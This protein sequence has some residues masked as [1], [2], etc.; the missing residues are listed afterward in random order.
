MSHNPTLLIVDDE[1][2][3]RRGLIN[4]VP[5]SALGID[6]IYEAENGR[7]ALL[8]LEEFQPDILLTDIRMPLMNGIDLATEVAARLPECKI[9]FLSG[10]SDKE[11]LKAAIHLGA[12]NYVEKPIDIEEVSNAVA[13]AVE[14]YWAEVRKPIGMV[15][16]MTV[17][18]SIVEKLVRNNAVINECIPLMESLNVRISEEGN[19]CTLVVKIIDTIESIQVPT[20]YHILEQ[21]LSDVFGK[22]QIIGSIKDMNHL[23][24]IIGIDKN[25]SLSDMRQFQYNMVYNHPSITAKIFASVS[26]V[27]VGLRNVFKAYQ[28]SVIGLQMLFFQGYG[29]IVIGNVPIVATD[30]EFSERNITKRFMNFLT[31]KAYDQLI[32]FIENEFKGIRFNNSLVVNDLKNA[33]FRMCILLHNHAR[34]EVAY[35]GDENSDNPYLWEQI[36]KIETLQELKLYL[37]NEIDMIVREVKLRENYS[38]SIRSVIQ[39][40]K[41]NYMDSEL[42]TKNLAD[43]VF[44][45]T[46][47]LS[48]LFKKETGGNISDFIRSVRIEAAKLKLRESNDSLKEI[49]EKVGYTDPNYF[50]KMFKKEVGRSPSDYRERQQT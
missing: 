4:N 35:E 43:Q 30:T 49:S 23:I 46:S 31:S 40:I 1:S 9:I 7:Q 38:T 6:T 22:Q 45:T 48:G 27:V 19:L 3:T 44:L 32:P 41:D 14:L 5:W 12:V 25:H 42:S 15:D 16:E 10:F 50:A 39:L 47:Y 21:C 29:N 11:Y 33:V 8:K 17:K 26:D 28:N 18:H 2:V 37:L 24:W 34:V 13:K 36:F 20:I